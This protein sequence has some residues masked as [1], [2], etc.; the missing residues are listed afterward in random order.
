MRTWIHRAVAFV[1]LVALVTA[2]T[3][4][5]LLHAQTDDFPRTVRDL[6]GLAVV[7]PTRAAHVIVIGSDPALAHV[8]TPHELS[9]ITRTS[10]PAAT[11]WTGVGLL[12][13]PAGDAL[14]FPGWSAAADAAGVP[15]FRTIPITDLAQWRTALTQFGAATGR[16]ARAAAAIAH[17]DARLSAI[18]ARVGQR[19]PVHVLIV[20]PEGY[21]FGRNTMITALLGAAGGIN[22]A[23]DAG[24]ADF[25]QIDDSAILALR[26]AVILLTPAWGQAGRAAFAA[27]DAY[28]NIPAV[29]SGRVLVFPFSPTTP[30][31]PGAAALMLA[32]LL[33]PAAFLPNLTTP[34]P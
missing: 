8:V 16:D 25:R 9:V 20:T 21:T 1:A 13:I 34:G 22:A 5:D 15:I 27:Q 23:A 4:P 32:L 19:A 33:H 30:A 2:P 17:L 7:I 31:D 28:A 10:D 6:T 14:A 26:P 3:A 11:D 12:V 24:Y 18:A 29:Q